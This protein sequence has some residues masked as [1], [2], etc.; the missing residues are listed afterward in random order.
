MLSIHVELLLGSYQAADPF[1]SAGAVEWPPHPYRLHAALVAAACEAGG[2]RADDDAIAA[3]TWLER[4]A[5]PAITCSTTMWQRTIATS[6]VPRNPTPGAE[7]KRYLKQ[8]TAENRVGR[9]FPTAVP[10]DPRVTFTWDAPSDPPPP[11]G[12]LVERVTW[13]GSSRSPVACAILNDAPEPTF[14]PTRVGR[15]QV[16][17]AAT[18]IT[19]ALLGGRFAYPQPVVA[20][21]VAYDDFARPSESSLE[22]AFS[23]L[24]VRRVPGAIQDAADTPLLGAALRAAVLSQAGDDAPAAL[25]GHASER[26]HAAYLTLPDVGH[27]GARGAVRG[28]ALA[29]PRD[30]DPLERETCLAAFAR[31]RRITLPGRAPLTVDDEVDATPLA[32]ERWV[33]PATHWATVTPII[34][35]RFP[36]RGRTVRDELLR[37]FVNAGLPEPR[38]I[39]PLAGPALVGGPTAGHLRGEVPPGLRVHARVEFASAI[40][41]PVAAGRGRY[42]GIG[43]LK[44]ERA[45]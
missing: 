30:L 25:H 7:W 15:R 13:L 2:D 45:R 18:G 24:L 19:G 4:L 20:P 26:G 22:G 17:V 31:L 11:L 27:R 28:V 41:G 8:G 38:D 10:A 23:E 37:S 32:V 1:G 40:R 44:P 42:R 21:I 5:P 3:L 36:R 6:Y 35:D 12:S 43:L 34:L 14:V 16:R 29:L 9:V 33:G 39:E